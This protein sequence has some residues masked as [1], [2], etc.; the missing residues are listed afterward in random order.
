[1]VGGSSRIPAFQD[2]LRRYFSRE[3][4]FSRNLDEDVARGA[5]LIGTLKT[6]TAN[7]ASPLA[8]L[9]APVDR[10]SHAIGVEALG[11]RAC[12]GTSWCCGQ[13]AHPDHAAGGGDL[14]PHPPTGRT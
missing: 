2:L 7:P 4:Q 9:P 12:S 11:V 5:A 10:S 6:G 13:H 1:M 3:P 8:S 14:R